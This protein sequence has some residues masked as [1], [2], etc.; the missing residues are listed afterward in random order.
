MESERKSLKRRRLE[1]VAVKEMNKREK[2]MIEWSRIRQRKGN[3]EVKKRKGGNKSMSKI[4][5]S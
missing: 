4:S 2:R 3:R 1:R 5:E